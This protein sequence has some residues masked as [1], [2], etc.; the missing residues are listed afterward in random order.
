MKVKIYNE[1]DK[2][3]RLTP[4]ILFSRL[5]KNLYLNTLALLYLKKTLRDLD[6]QHVELCPPA[7]RIDLSTKSKAIKCV[8]SFKN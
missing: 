1:L 4:R 8:Y 7:S 3:I 5:R 2:S 6:V